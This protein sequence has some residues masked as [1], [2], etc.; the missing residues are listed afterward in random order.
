MLPE[1]SCDPI[2]LHS[3]TVGLVWTL[4]CNHFKCY[5]IPLQSKIPVTLPQ[6]N[7]KRFHLELLALS[8][9]LSPLLYCFSLLVLG[10]SAISLFYLLSPFSFDT[11]F[12]DSYA[13]SLT[14]ALCFSLFSYSEECTQ[15]HGVLYLWHKDAS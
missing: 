6:S 14:Y 1:R 4:E 13:L 10:F 3:C 11:S 8:C 5:I 7:T 12:L 9:G 15:T 2:H